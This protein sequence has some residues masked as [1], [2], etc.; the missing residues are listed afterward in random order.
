MHYSCDFYNPI[1]GS[2]WESREPTDDEKRIAN[3]LIKYNIKPNNI[4]HIGI[5]NNLFHSLFPDAQITGITLSLFE[6]EKALHFK[7]KNYKLI[8]FDKYNPNLFNIL[9]T[10]DYIIDNN[11]CSYRCCDQHAYLYLK[12]II[13]KLN[14]DGKILSDMAGWRYGFNGRPP[15]DIDEI[16]KFAN[17]KYSI[18]NNETIIIQKDDNK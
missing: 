17:A 14:P 4:L 13:N 6:Y 10:Y 9:D 2:V 12:T 15:L 5:G 16:C 8:L 11:I 7:S 3:Y 18:V 1:K